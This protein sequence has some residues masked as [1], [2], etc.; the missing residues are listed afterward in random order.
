MPAA[1]GD[2]RE[3]LVAEERVAPLVIQVKLH[4]D[5]ISA[6]DKAKWLSKVQEMSVSKQANA[7]GLPVIAIFNE[8]SDKA[9]RFQAQT[10][11]IEPSHTAEPGTRKR[12]DHHADRSKV[13]SL[14]R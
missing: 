11:V 14:F 7:K 10:R 4:A 3:A 1:G 13:L 5:Q 9:S 12:E 8:V 2:P 6:A